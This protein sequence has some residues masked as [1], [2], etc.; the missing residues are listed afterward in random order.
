MCVVILTVFLHTRQQRPL[1]SL[2]I[3]KLRV[4][5]FF[6]GHSEDDRAGTWIDM[7]DEILIFI[8]PQ[9][10]LWHLK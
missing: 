4:E 1:G 8:V 2:W 3:S 10:V 6:E 7:K 9:M 5:K